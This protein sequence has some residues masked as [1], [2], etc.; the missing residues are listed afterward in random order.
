MSDEQPA[1][2]NKLQAT[3]NTVFDRLFR[4]GYQFDF[5]KAVQLLEIFFANSPQEG[6]GGAAVESH[7][8]IRP[9][10]GLAFPATDVRSVELLNEQPSEGR[11]QRARVTA[12]FM[13]L[14]GIDSPLPVYFYNEIATETDPTKPLRDFLD[15]FNHRVYELFYRA[16]KKYRPALHYTGDDAHSQ[17]ALCLAGLA[18]P[19]MF[20]K[21][22]LRLAAFAGRLSCR[23][24]N[25]KGLKNLIEDFFPSLRVTIRENEP[26]WWAIPERPRMGNGDKPMKLGANATIGEKIFDVSGKFRLVLAPLTLVEYMDFLPGGGYASIIQYLVRLYAPDYLDFDVELRLKT[27]EIPRLRMG[28]KGNQLG[29]TTWSGRPSGELT[30]RVVV[31][32]EAKL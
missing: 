15:M 32:E 23:V 3:S 4:E 16:W 27:A 11:P 18:T 17:R 19:K 14:Y 7:I 10:S 29:L 1:T 21:P 26:R 9:H 20:H 12:T 2:S 8:R 30:S 25:A 24:R 28:M 6:E 5:F 22:P 13:G 31:Y